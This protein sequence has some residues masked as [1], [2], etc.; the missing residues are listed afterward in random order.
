[1]K[2]LIKMAAIAPL[3]VSTLAFAAKNTFVVENFVT[4]NKGDARV[5]DIDINEDP[6][7]LSPWIKDNFDFVVL[8]NKAN[9]NFTKEKPKPKTAVPGA[10][11]TATLL[12]RGANGLEIVKTT[13]VSTGRERLEMGGSAGTLTTDPYISQTPNGYY[14]PT[15]FSIDHKSGDWGHEDK[16]GEIVGSAMP[17]AMFFNGGK[18]THQVPDGQE[19]NLGKRA[20]GAC[21]RMEKED[22]EYVFWAARSTGGALT[23]AELGDKKFMAGFNKQSDLAGGQF[24][25]STD[26]GCRVSL[27][28]DGSGPIP[29]NGKDSEG[30]ESNGI[31][32]MVK[33]YRTLVIVQNVRANGKSSEEFKSQYGREFCYGKTGNYFDFRRADHEDCQN[34][35]YVMQP[36]YQLEDDQEQF[37]EQQ[38]IVKPRNAQDPRSRASESYII[39]G[40]EWYLIDG[41]VYRLSTDG[42]VLK[43]MHMSR[44][45]LRDLA[46]SSQEVE[47]EDEGF[48]PFNFNLFGN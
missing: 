43:D 42:K 20:S 1:M 28:D 31:Y 2:S 25:T 41:T 32:Q 3:L 10:P 36:G 40:R 8:I 48:N 29:Y 16:N 6:Y 23:P 4:L 9:N 30:C 27:A 37:F 12:V 13:Y 34:F 38:Q 14:R 46:A 7:N 19:G 5:P 45:E 44:R 39:D 26:M 17:F 47:R 33:G 35:S 22:A 21:V 18:A 24:L 15:R 11:Q